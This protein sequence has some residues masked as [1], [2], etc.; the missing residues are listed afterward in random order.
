MS[1]R[2]TYLPG[3]PCWVAVFAADPHA[4][5]DFY[6]PVF[7]WAFTGPGG[8]DDSPYYEAT[9]DGARVAGI[10]TLPEDAASA[11]MTN[12]CVADVE[13]TARRVGHEHPTHS[14]PGRGARVLR[15]RFRLAG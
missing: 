12:V 3:V 4:A 14:R 7:G 15:G 1:T 8:P 5:R 13:E 9:L 10:G 6:G 11:W 2:T